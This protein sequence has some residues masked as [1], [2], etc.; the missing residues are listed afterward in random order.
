MNLFY[1]FHFTVN[2]SVVFV[3]KIK[4]FIIALF[5]CLYKRKAENKHKYFCFHALILPFG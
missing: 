1:N 2:V 4:N 5:V 3:L